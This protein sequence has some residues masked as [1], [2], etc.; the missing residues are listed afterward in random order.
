MSRHGNHRRHINESKE[1]NNNKNGSDMISTITNLLS[2]INPEDITA[3]LASLKLGGSKSVNQNDVIQDGEIFHN[4][5]QTQGQTQG[6][7]NFRNNTTSDFSNILKSFV[8]Y[9]GS[10][11]IGRMLQMFGAGN[12]N[13]K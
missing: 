11:N 3:L 1:N 8:S 13:K 4:Q 12:L 5:G 6:Q 9:A 7:N 2:N 10:Q